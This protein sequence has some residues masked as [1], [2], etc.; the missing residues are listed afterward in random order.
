MD[1]ELF[2]LHNNCWRSGKWVRSLSMNYWGRGVF[3]KKTIGDPISLVI[4]SNAA[5]ER[6]QFGLRCERPGL[7]KK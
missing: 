7:K 5:L 4:R 1:G 6:A 3:E 2:F